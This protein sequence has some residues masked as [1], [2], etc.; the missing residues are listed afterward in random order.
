MEQWIISDTH[1][2]HANII[3]YT[4]RPFKNVLDMDIK[5]ARWWNNL[6]F[7]DDIVWHLGDVG[8]FP[9]FEQA[10]EF[11]SQL[12]GRKRLIL[13]NHDT[14]KKM[15]TQECVDYWIAAG[16]E[17]VFQHPVEYHCN[18]RKILL[19]HY[20]RSTEGRYSHVIHGHTH[21]KQSFK[22]KNINVCV[23]MTNYRPIPFNSI[24][25]SILGLDI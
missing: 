4:G 9:K 21:E 14:Y 8:F 2:S 20:P 11:I 17:M 1:F 7:E 25:D 24:I 23:E 19:S 12:N 6:I 13:G 16:F 15:C 3:K 18:G 10:E 22:R 5:M